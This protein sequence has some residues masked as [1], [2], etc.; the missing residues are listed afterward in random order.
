MRNN[1]PTKGKFG[2]NTV[3]PSGSFRNRFSLK[4]KKTSSGPFSE[5]DLIGQG[6]FQTQAFCR[7]A[8]RLWVE[9]RA[10]SCGFYE[11]IYALLVH[12]SFIMKR[13]AVVFGAT[14]LVGTEL[15]EQL[16]VNPDYEDVT[17]VVRHP[18]QRK[19]NNKLREILLGDFTRLTDIKEQLTGDDY[20]CCIGTTI[21][22]AGSQAAF[23]AVDLYI[24]I[25]IAEMAKELS[26]SNLVVISSLGANSSS[27]NFYLHTKGE[28]ENAV[29]KVYDGNLKIVRPSLLLGNRLEYRFIEKLSMHFMTIFGWLFIGPLKKVKAI[30]ANAVAG[31]MIKSIALPNDKVF[32]ESDE[33]QKI[34]DG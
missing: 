12:N 5:A 3:H 17:I 2:K 8:C 22:K 7:L 23:K 33:L 13:K 27:R 6:A 4:R 20:F 18:V 24:P 34:S 9:A 16:L 10:E 32:I 1:I 28:M 11:R 14:G 25:T 26:V 19:S 30:K 21:K 29:R 15:V 31:A